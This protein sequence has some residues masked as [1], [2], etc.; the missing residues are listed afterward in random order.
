MHQ[1][2]LENLESADLHQSSIAGREM[3][4]PHRLG[5]VDPAAHPQGRAT[6]LRFE[7]PVDL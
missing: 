7:A 3:T 2:Q 4:G 6:R 5:V 1:E